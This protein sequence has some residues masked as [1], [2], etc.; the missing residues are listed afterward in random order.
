MWNTVIYDKLSMIFGALFSRSSIHFCIYYMY[1]IQ[2]GDTIFPLIYDEFVIHL[3]LCKCGTL[4]SIKYDFWGTVFPL[5]YSF[6]I[7]G[8]LFSRSSIHFCILW[9]MTNL[10]ITLGPSHLQELELVSVQKCRSIIVTIIMHTFHAI[11]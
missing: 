8:V 1:F 6:L 9:G 10:I 11:S 7:F 3:I 5:I 4:S 2:F